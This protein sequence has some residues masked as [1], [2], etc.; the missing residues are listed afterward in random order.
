MAVVLEAVE[1]RRI[2]LERVILSSIS[3]QVS[4][5]EVLF[6][7]GPPRVGKTHLLRCLALLDPL[8]VGVSLRN[9]RPGTNHAPRRAANSASTAAPL[10]SLASPPGAHG[11]A[12]S[13]PTPHRCTEPLLKLIFLRRLVCPHTACATTHHFISSHSDSLRSE[14]VAGVTF[15]RSL[16]TLG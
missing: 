15:Q 1:L 9:I 3:F 7:F 16:Q 13:H 8:Q 11:L 10:T 4:A 14:V 2:V 6:V 5:G 12:T